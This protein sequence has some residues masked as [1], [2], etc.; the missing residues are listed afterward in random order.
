MGV[1]RVKIDGKQKGLEPRL[2]DVAM[3]NV[4]IRGDGSPNSVGSLSVQ[5]LSGF[6]QEKGFQKEIVD[7]LKGMVDFFFLFKM[8][9]NKKRAKEC[10]GGKSIVPE[11]LPAEKELW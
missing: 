9:F 8:Y 2:P 4:A 10:F 11:K 3:A 5:A 1:D 6:L 7:S